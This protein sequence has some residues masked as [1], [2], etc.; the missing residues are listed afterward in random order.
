[1]ARTI[2]LTGAT[3]G[4]GLE[5][6]R[7]LRERGDRTILVGRRAQADLDASLFSPETYCRADLSR[8][9]AADQIQ[10]FV[11]ERG[12]RGLDLLIHNAGTGWYGPVERQTGAS[13]H[14]AVAVNLWTPIALTHALAPLV[15]SAGG[16]IVFVS[17]VVASLA[18]PDYAVYGATKSALEGFARSLRTESGHSPRIQIVR[19]GATRTGLHEKIGLSRDVVDW[20]RFPPAA[21]VAKEVL[22][23]IEKRV[24]VATIGLANRL[25]G[26]LGA[27]LPAACDVVPR[28]RRRNGRHGAGSDRCPPGHCVITGAAQGIGKALAARFSHAGWRVTG[29][30]LPTGP[31]APCG[32]E[33]LGQGRPGSPPAPAA[34]IGSERSLHENSLLGADLASASDLADLATRLG[35]GTPIDC[36]IHNAGVNNV[37]RFVD[38]ELSRQRRVLEVNLLAPLLLTAALLDRGVLTPGGSLAFLSSLS[39]YV[40]YPGAAVYAATKDGL[41]SYARSL[42]VALADR[43]INVLTVFPGPTRTAHARRHSPDNRFEERRMAPETVADRI[44][45]AVVR[46]RRQ[47][48]PGIGNRLTATLGHHWPGMADRIMRWAILEKLDRQRSC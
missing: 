7:L 26:A 19:P 21:V 14:E 24:P 43:D 41:A 42:S 2:L 1:M 11:A 33:M 22:D 4:I 5:L 16:S 25:I 47:L 23:A 37:G 17:S 45:R 46:R 29:I 13:I 31:T 34:G 12:V 27:R 32:E 28:R 20:E 15:R 30:D 18:C 35:G 10:R 44:H 40:G 36:L 6:A 38:S 48:I 39:R 9:D 3:D 8:S